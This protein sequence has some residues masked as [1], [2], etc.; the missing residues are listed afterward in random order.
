M[1]NEEFLVLFTL[2]FTILNFDVN[3]DIKA[4]GERREELLKE[5]L[6]ERKLSQD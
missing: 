6:D 4:G 5:I 2:F 1:T 3:M